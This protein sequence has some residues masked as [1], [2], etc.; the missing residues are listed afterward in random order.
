VV[1]GGKGGALPPPC[2]ASFEVFDEVTGAA[3][4]IRSPQTVPA[5]NFSR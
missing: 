4:A 5:T 1:E 3:T 2:R